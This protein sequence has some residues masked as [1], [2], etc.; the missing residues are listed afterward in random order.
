LCL[1]IGVLPAESI[2][3]SRHFCNLDPGFSGEFGD[4]PFTE[5]YLDQPCSRGTE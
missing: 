3:L 5:N 2:A 1:C 4:T